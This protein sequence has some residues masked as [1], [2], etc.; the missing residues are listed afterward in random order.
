MR[1]GER[2][3]PYTL[4]KLNE[5]IVALNPNGQLVGYFPELK[6][7]PSKKSGKRSVSA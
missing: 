5:T 1:G 7:P 2:M 6:Q 3:R 4:L